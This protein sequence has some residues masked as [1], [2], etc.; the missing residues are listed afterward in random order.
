MKPY[1]ISAITILLFAFCS[2]T[3]SQNSHGPGKCCFSFTPTKIPVAM[4]VHFEM[5]NPACN[6]P[7]V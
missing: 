1:C 7:G 5:T 6:K 2:L 4:V 3:L